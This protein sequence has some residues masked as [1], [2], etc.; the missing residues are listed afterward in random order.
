MTIIGPAGM[1]GQPRADD[2]EV[3]VNTMCSAIE[4]T[5]AASEAVVPCVIIMDDE[6]LDTDLSG[7]QDAA[8]DCNAVGSS[9][10]LL[11]EDGAAEE[12]YELLPWSADCVSS[13]EYWVE[14]GQVDDEGMFLFPAYDPDDPYIYFY[15][16]EPREEYIPWLKNYLLGTLSNI[17][18]DHTKIME[19]VIG[20]KPARNTDIALLK[21]NYDLCM[22]IVK[23]SD[24]SLN[25]D[26][27][28]YNANLQG[29]YR[30]QFY[31]DI[32]ETRSNGGALDD[33]K[34]V[35]TS[36]SETSPAEWLE[37]WINDLGSESS[38]S[39]P[40]SESGILQLLEVP[41]VVTAPAVAVDSANRLFHEDHTY[42]S[43]FRP[44]TDAGWIGNIKKYAIC[45]DPAAC[46][47][48]ELLDVTDAAATGSDNLFLST[49]QSFWSAGVDG[50]AV[51][52]GGA[53]ENL[54][55]YAS[56]NVYTYLG[57]D[58][59]PD[60]PATLDEYALSNSNITLDMLGGQNL[61]SDVR[62]AI[63]NWY[64]GKDVKDEDADMVT[65]EDRPWAFFSPLH[66]RPNIVQYADPDGG[67]PIVKIVVG[68]NDGTVRMIDAATGVEDFAFVAP[69]MLADHTDMF[70]AVGTDG[71]W[72]LD[73]GHV[74]GMDGSPQVLVEDT[75]N[76]GTADKHTLIIGMRRG[77]G[78]YYA[79]DISA[80]ADG[81][82]TPKFLW[83]IV[84]GDADAGYGTM[85][86][87][88]SAPLPV[89]LRVVDSDPD[90]R[91]GLQVINALVLG[92]GYTIEQDSGFT[93]STTGN[94]LYIVDPSDGSIL[95]SIG[96]PGFGGDIELP[97]MTYPIPGDLSPVDS[98]GD[99]AIERIYF[100]DTGGQ[101]WRVD[102][103]TTL[104]DST[105]GRLAV[106]ATAGTPA[107]ERR[108]YVPPEVTP[109]RDTS[110]I[111]KIQEYDVISI[112]SG[113]RGHPLDKIVEDRL[114]SIRDY[115]VGSQINIDEFDSTPTNYPKCGGGESLAICSGPLT[116]SDLF[117]ATD[118]AIQAGTDTEVSEAELAI[119]SKEG[120]FIKFETLDEDGNLSVFGEKGL[121]K[122]TVVDGMLLAT[123][124]TPPQTCS[125]WT[126]QGIARLYSVDLL[127]GEALF[128]EFDGVDGLTTLDRFMNI[129]LGLPSMPVPVFQEKG[130]TFLVGTGGGSADNDPEISPPVSATFWYKK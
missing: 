72:G 10:E 35:A 34:I 100:A 104:S 68:L 107:D 19:K 110:G 97:N 2:I 124:Y 15:D 73:L 63:M 111:S 61:S 71:M 86:Q 39:P 38:S 120:W 67:D 105:G 54:P 66:S 52:A 113:Y 49:A 83:R 7:V 77:G 79:L 123:T 81:A 6:A 12:N 82:I 50:N 59:S 114:Y 92:A 121:S 76:D 42:I 102:L 40:G 116:E 115:L 24:V 36:V 43:L 93:T 9:D 70:A 125:D 130:V 57:T 74:Y 20:I 98:D 127:T 64:R 16:S 8:S 69:V 58:D 91:S 80:D 44:D 119:S 53:G 25:Y 45:D 41:S 112:A 126:G 75:D 55:G 122:T 90:S 5:P 46:N 31:F 14:S 27:G 78:V 23:E 26:A 99:G 129:G 29:K 22:A 21:D 65:E 4:S 85:G 103:A 108:F 11:N 48:G 33:I 62:T 56:R 37:T 32:V 128:Q 47:L 89:A 84:A 117:D 18:S 28:E 106:L 60:S 51:N 118:N 94:G 30:G 87:S 109:V 101:V 17:H 96:G 3:F 88:W 1:G 95:L 13:T